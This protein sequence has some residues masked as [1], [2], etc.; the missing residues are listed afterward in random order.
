[1]A[2]GTRPERKKEELA[3][4]KAEKERLEASGI[5]QGSGHAG[6]VTPCSV[7]GQP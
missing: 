6:L 7:A 5:G 2:I 1:M 4:L 3:Q